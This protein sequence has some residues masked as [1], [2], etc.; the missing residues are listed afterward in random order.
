MHYILLLYKTY[1]CYCNLCGLEPSCAKLLV[2]LSNKFTASFSWFLL[3]VSWDA[4]SIIDLLASFFLGSCV[5][6]LL[7]PLRAIFFLSCTFLRLYLAATFDHN[8]DRFLFWI[9]ALIICEISNDPV[10]NVSKAS[11]LVF[12]VGMSWHLGLVV[13]VRCVALI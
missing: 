5:P 10:F 3:V 4:D 6:C 11:V 13:D 12:K 1:I 8:E 9:R 2:S 7:S